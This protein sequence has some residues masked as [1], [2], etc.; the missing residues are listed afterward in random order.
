[1]YINRCQYKIF[2][3]RKKMF[4]Y[5]ILLILSICTTTIYP[6]KRVTKDVFFN[7]LSSKTHEHQAGNYL[8]KLKDASELKKL[9]D[10]KVIRQLSNQHY[11]IQANTN[12]GISSINDA[13][14]YHTP[15]NDGYK[16]S[17]NLLAY[18]WKHPKSDIQLILNTS[19][20]IS[21]TELKQYGTILDADNQYITIQT[22]LQYLPQLLAI[23]AV[24]FA[25]IKRKPREEFSINSMDLSTNQVSNLHSLF[26]ATRGAGIIASIKENMFD[27]NDLDLLGRSIYSNTQSTTYSQHATIMA[28]LIGGNGTSYINGLGA[29]PEV[30]L[31]SSDF[32]RLMPDDI[33]NLSAN[34]IS[35]QNHSYGTNI[36]N[37]YGAE[38]RE[39]DQQVY[40]TDT[41][42]HVFSAGNIGTTIPQLGVYAGLSNHANLTGTFKQAKNAL[43]IGGIDREDIVQDLS[44]KGPAYDGRIKPEV[45]ASGEDGTS[46]AA[47]LT[48]GVVCLLKQKFKDKF[49][50]S[51]SAALLKSI[52]INTAND[53]GNPQVDYS[54]GFGKLNACEAMKT[55]DE[56]RFKSDIILDGQDLSYPIEINDSVKEFKVSLAWNDLAAT[57]NSPQ[58]LINDLDLWIEDSSGNKTLPWVLNSSPSIEAISANA[59]RQKDHLNNVEQVTLDNPTPGSYTI[60]VYG[61]HVTQRAQQ[62]HFSYQS[63]IAHTFEW[64]F[65][66]KDDQLFAADINYLRYKNTF[67]DPGSL[68]VSF[69]DGTTWSLITPSIQGNSSFYKWQTPDIFTK[70]LLKMT[71]NGQDFIS[72]SFSISRPVNFNVGYN[73]ENELLL[74][75]PKQTE[76][77]GY[78]IY[79]VK[80]NIL[81]ALTSTTDTLIQIPKSITESNYFAIKANGVADL[82]GLKGFT[83]DAQ[84]QGVACY[85]KSLLANVGSNGITVTLK[86]GST[87]GLSGTIRCEKL[88]GPDIYATIGSAVVTN[89]LG[90]TFVDVEPRQ[91]VQYYRAILTTT[92]GDSIISAITSAIYLDKQQFV[93]FPNPVSEQFSVLSGTVAEYTLSIYDM[94]GKQI[95]TQALNSLRHD[96]S[97]TQL[98]SGTY[99]C[100]I[101]LKGKPIYEMKLI[102]I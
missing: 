42:V 18:W 64:N 25:D 91:G 59:A 67:N 31:I 15:A 63:T 97:A 57:L 45:V 33:S 51:P 78:T 75:W 50:Q 95:S 70:A 47:A 96:L 90:Y 49:H 79:N 55:I 74:Y 4:K 73:C 92:Q 93:L 102:K 52:L 14:I 20:E 6:Q 46:G 24:K 81:Q 80:N 40:Q 12:T 94:A 34:N 10:L 22:R 101:T 30:T 17:D 86:L 32:S 8:I 60:H 65:P 36:E 2:F 82:T 69:D 37:Y 39:Y 83:L 89:S 66:T 43:V 68:S 62:F 56:S 58:A 16:A 48:S 5:F 88:I 19:S 3:Q 1:M 35:V 99:I 85:V 41:L 53:V 7:R 84:Q 61:N 9:A 11:V 21:S 29:A 27:R 71:I 76:S 54:S 38:A 26:P 98:S 23:P 77:T 13:M 87:M 44:S 72:Q 28:T 100:K